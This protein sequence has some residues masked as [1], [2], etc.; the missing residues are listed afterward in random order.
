MR[1]T[2]RFS[3]AIRGSVEIIKL[4]SLLLRLRKRVLTEDLLNR[5]TCR[6]HSVSPLNNLRNGVDLA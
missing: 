4:T 1:H 6:G 5:Q 2:P 3:V